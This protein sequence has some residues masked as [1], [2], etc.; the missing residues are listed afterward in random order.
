MAWLKV[1][2]KSGNHEAVA[3]TE[4]IDPVEKTVSV[5]QMSSLGKSSLSILTH[6]MK[7]KDFSGKEHRGGKNQKFW[8]SLT[9]H[10]DPGPLDEGAG[11][12]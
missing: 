7:S 10:R 2:V 3:T 11:P 1:K 9:K 5:L 12:D 6:E 4:N 8:K